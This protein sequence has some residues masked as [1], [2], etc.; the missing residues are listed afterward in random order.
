[1]IKGI[2]FDFDGTIINTNDLIVESLRKASETVLG[3]KLSDSLLNKILGRTLDEQMHMIDETHKKELE[4]FYREYYNTHREAGTFLYEG[5]QKVFEVI[6]QDGYQMSILS[7][8]STRGICHG[9][10]KFN[11]DQYFPVICSMDDVEVGKPDPEGINK[12]LKE[13]ELTPEEVIL[14]GDSPHD[15]E[16]G[17]ALGIKTVLVDWSIIPMDHF[18][19]QPDEIINDPTDLLKFIK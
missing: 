19:V 11:L 8:K 10:E 4:A 6:H 13:M 16:A 5:F 15:I 12:V 17:H 18:E 2:I 1:M 14:V 9:L 7:N 3:K